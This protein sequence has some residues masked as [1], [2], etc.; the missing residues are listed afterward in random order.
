MGYLT[1]TMAHAVEQRSEGWQDLL[2]HDGEKMRLGVRNFIEKYS[3]V[4][5]MIVNLGNEP[6]S[7]GE[8]VRANVEAYRIVYEEIKRIDPSIYVVGTSIGPNDDFARYGYGKWCDAYDFHVYESAESVRDIVSD[9]YPAM[10]KKYGEAKPIWSTELGLNSQGMARISVASELYR[11]AVN[12]FAGGGACMSWFG[13]LYPDPEGKNYD[14]FGSAHNVF[15]C[16]YNCYAPKMDAI[17]YYNMVNSLTIKKYVEDRIYGG[18]TRAFLF[19]DQ[20]GNCLQVLYNEQGRSDEFIPLAGVAAVKSIGVDGRIR[21]FDAGGKGLTLTISEEP[22]LLLYKAEKPC[23]PQELGVPTGTFLKTPSQMVAGEAGTFSIALDGMTR[24]QVQLLL[25]P[26]WTEVQ[27]EESMEQGST[28]LTFTIK[29]TEYSTAREADI[30]LLLTDADGRTA[31][32][33]SYRP[34]IAGALSLQV[35]PNPCE[36]AGKASIDL[37][38]QNNSASEQ[39]LDWEVVLYGEQEL[40]GGTFTPQHTPVAYFTTTPS[41]SLTLQGNE[42]QVLTLNMEDV[43]WYKVYR[44]RAT[45][46]DALGRIVTQER[47]VSAFYGVPKARKSIQVDGMLDDAD[48]QR[49]PV[50]TLDSLEQFFAFVRREASV[51]DWAGPDDLSADIRYLWD[52]DYFYVSLDVKDDVAGKIIQADADLWQQDG[53]QFLFDPVRTQLYKIGKYEYSIGE[54]TKGVQTWCTLSATGSVSTGNK[55]DVKAAIHRAGD[56]TGNVTYE[57]AFPWECLAPF[58]PGKGANLGL[59]LIVNEDDG[60]GRNAYMTWFGDVNSKDVDTVGDLILTE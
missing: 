3:H 7:K 15:D 2:A 4:R 40:H 41:G 56:G 11:K 22:V 47:P 44:V 48:W 37:K 20:E 21:Q 57:I 43:D 34:I 32:C 53:L 16:R 59:A 10:F 51:Q 13:L 29:G 55:T 52:E 19:A 25:P 27:C 30:N 24:Q 36:E 58:K 8:D 5:P 28:M 9:R 1:G 35:L 49:A 14:S 38:I 18:N 31:G 46:R 60:E 45:V 26:F 50:R 17:A 39:T 54:G 42:T 6:H 33:L 23:L 12:F